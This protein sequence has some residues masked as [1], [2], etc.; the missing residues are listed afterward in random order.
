MCWD[1]VPAI[2]QNGEITMYEVHYNPLETFDGQISTESTNT[3]LTCTDLTG[4]EEYVEYTISVRAYTSAGPGPYSDPV[5]ER[6]YTDS[7][8]E[9][10]M[11]VYI[12]FYEFYFTE[13]DA[14]PQNSTAA[15]LSST[16]I[17]LCWNQV[18]AI[19]QNGEITMYE[20][21][22]DPLETFKGQ[23]STKTVNITI[24][25]LLC[26]VLTGLEEYVQ[27]NISVRAYTSAGPGPY[28]DPVT[29]R[30]D[31]DSKGEFYMISN[32]K[33]C[34]NSILQSQMHLQ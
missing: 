3:S 29:E 14:P 8:G 26:A 34:E 19:N 13:P 5:T 11:I 24:T 32:I 23:I 9:I 21:Q 16:E 1:Q 17:R 7:K 20:V 4:L 15:E 25:S 6:T 28:S 27:Y 30:T 22:Y 18:P 12:K 33:V 2:N 31:S 10:N